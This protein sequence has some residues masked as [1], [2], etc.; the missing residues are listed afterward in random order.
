MTG[1]GQGQCDVGGWRVAIEIRSVNHR[2]ADLRLRIPT[3]LA[4]WEPQVRRRVLKGV[5]RGRVELTVRT[6]AKATSGEPKLQREW[7][8]SVLSTAEELRNEY[9]VEG[10]LS[11]ADLMRMPALMRTE[12]LA[13]EAGEEELAALDQA[14]DA[15][16][17]SHDADRLREGA[18]L[19]TDLSARVS[20]MRELAEQ[21]KEH[22]GALPKRLQERLVARIE[23][24]TSDVPLDPSRVAQEAALLADRSDVT[25][26]L[27]RLAGHL[28]QAADLVEKPDGQPLGKRLDFLLQEIHRE[29]NTINSKSS[30][31]ALTRVA[32]SMKAEAEKVR[33]QI[34]NVE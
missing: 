16:C 31:L 3:E 5:K 1:F 22:A 10:D 23:Q 29:T 26:E 2:Y 12:T 15:A 34:Q 6:E 21:M 11:V 27:V 18:G 20:T 9:G 19:A 14:L 7:V 4:I 8:Q 33:E 30:E 17:K 32:L 24:L 13:F 28:S 25:E